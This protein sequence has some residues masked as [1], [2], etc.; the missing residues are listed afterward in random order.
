M[1]LL[2]F[3]KFRTYDPD[4]PAGGGEGTVTPPADGGTTPAAG[5][6]VTPPTTP[7][8]TVTPAAPP[9]SYDPANV[10]GRYLKTPAVPT[11][12]PQD[13]SKPLTHADLV[14]HQERMQQVENVRKFHE[15][16]N[17]VARQPSRF[18]G[19]LGLTHAFADDRSLDSFMQATRDRLS[20][21][22]TADDYL[23]LHAGPTLLQQAY[24]KGAKDYE[25]KLKAG[26]VSIPAPAQQ[27][28]TQ[29]PGATQPVVP[30]KEV[31]KTTT[32]KVADV[33]EFLKNQDPDYYKEFMAGRVKLG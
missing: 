33:G 10:M 19:E 32:G 27:T 1:F 4:V 18:G 28:Q 8:T 12:S 15:Q 17:R 9:P 14:A 24:E 22:L 5:S 6:P 30:K 16:M 31:P 11:L 25:N 3:F 20:N 29:T 2:P 23:F 26:K 7:G 13:A 21:G